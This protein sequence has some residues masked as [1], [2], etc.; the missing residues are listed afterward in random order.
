[1]YMTDQGLS[2][3]KKRSELGTSLSVPGPFLNSNHYFFSNMKYIQ[4]KESRKKVVFIYSLFSIVS[5]NFSF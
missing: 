2:L 3:V 5:F 1:M 4:V